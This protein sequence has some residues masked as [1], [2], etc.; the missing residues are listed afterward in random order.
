MANDGITLTV[1]PGEI[2]GIL[3][4]NGAGKSTL[5]NILSGMYRADSGRILLDDQ[6]ITISSPAVAIRFGIGMLYQEPMDFPAMSVLE[7]FLAASPGGF[8]LS[9]KGLRRQFSD[10]TRAF[11]FALD[12][13]ARVADLTVG[14]RQQLEITRLLWLGA[15]TL[16]L[17]EPTT[18]IS[19]QQREKLFAVLRRLAAAG[20]SVL[21]VSHKLEEAQALCHRVTVLTQGKIVGT[22]TIP[23]PETELVHMMFGR[24][25]TAAPRTPAPIADTALSVQGLRT[26]DWRLELSAINLDVRAGEVIGLAGLEGSGQSL[27]LRACAGLI[28][29]AAG[30][31]SVNGRDLTGRPY[32]GFRAAGV[33]LVPANRIEE[34]LIQGLSLTEHVALATTGAGILIDWHRLRGATTQAIDTFHIK[35]RPDSLVNELSGGNQQRALL[36]LLPPDLSLLLMEHPTRGLDLESAE[37]VWSLLLERTQRGTAIMFSSADLDELRTRSD[38]IVVFFSGQTR[39]LPSSVATVERLGQ[40]IG[41][42]GFN[43]HAAL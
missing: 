8:F 30:T 28:R 12:P 14:E 35:G 39:E 37:Y 42:V 17:D 13:G 38:R 1:S 40:L 41:G 43:E 19:A 4:E 18:A 25:L 34:G 33:A 20:M 21:F 31:L 23:C 15:R 9:Y 26:G 32:S 10:L 3:G 2:H 24:P 16:I 22:T 6:Q 29:P 27:L 7:S 5:M 36:S 11:G